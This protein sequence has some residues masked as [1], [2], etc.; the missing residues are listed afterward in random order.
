ME[1]KRRIK[2][3]E[4]APERA[5]QGQGRAGGIKGGRERASF[6]GFSPEGKRVGQGPL[7]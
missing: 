2:R 1:E 6:G 4:H 7:P 5:E 3:R